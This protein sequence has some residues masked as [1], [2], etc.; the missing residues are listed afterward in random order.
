GDDLDKRNA[1]RADL[2]S[3]GYRV[4]QVTLDYED[5]LWNSPY[6][7]CVARGDHTAIAW[8]KSSY[9]D[10][11]A[12]YIDADR[13]MARMVFGHAINHVLL[14][15][16]GAFTG[17]ILPDLLKLLRDKGFTLATLEAVERDDAYRGNPNLASAQGGTLLEQWMETRG[18]A[19]P[20]VP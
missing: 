19:S 8:L 13:A 17:E 2:L 3:H 12:A 18:L 1:I 9:L 15:H 16:L 5:Y 14:L 11:A 7:R 4:A 6:A 10:T 20:S